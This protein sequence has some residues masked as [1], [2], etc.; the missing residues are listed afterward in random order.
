VTAIA[1]LFDV[2]NTLLDNDQVKRELIEAAER[3]LG[4]ERGARFWELYD[5]VRRELD[6]VDFPHT[7]ERFAREFPLEEGYPDFA[8][9][10]LSYPYHTAVYRGALDVLKAA[11]AVGS[12]AVLSDGDRVF[13][14]A[15]IARAR[16][17]AALTGPVLI[18]THKEDHLDEVE[19]I[20]PADHYVM[21]DDKPRIH[22]VMKERLGERVTTL[23]VRQGHYARMNDASTDGVD[24][25]VDAI[26]EILHMDL[27]S[28]PGRACG[29]P[30][31][32]EESHR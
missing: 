14:A 3:L 22:S 1:F 6:Y 5:E 15:K 23:L 16:I 19:R 26:A 29:Q 11:A 32:N 24:V 27:A 9:V 25:A 18:F 4:P 17:T 28:L 10:V 12:A 30:R 21:V 31:S 8:D 7:L 20:V 13:Q 2:D